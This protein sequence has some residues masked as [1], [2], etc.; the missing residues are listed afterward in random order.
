M[1]IKKI[2]SLSLCLLVGMVLS[3]P[4]QGAQSEKLSK[5]NILK[6]VEEGF[7]EAVLKDP[8]D[9][10]QMDFSVLPG[11]GNFS[12]VENNV[13]NFL[14]RGEFPEV[15]SG[16]LTAKNIKQ[17][18]KELFQLG[19]IAK[20]PEMPT[21]TFPDV[22]LQSP[23][24]PEFLTLYMKYMIERSLA[25]EAILPDKEQV[26]E[27]RKQIKDLKD[28]LFNLAKEEFHEFSPEIIKEQLDIL[29]EPID[30]GPT[31][32]QNTTAKRP[33]TSAQIQNIMYEWG[34]LAEKQTGFYQN[35]IDREKQIR[36]RAGRNIS[37]DEI[38][39]RKYFKKSSLMKYF[40]PFN[41]VL[42]KEYQNVLLKE[43]V[44]PQ[45]PER[46]VEMEKEFDIARG[47]N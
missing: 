12:R 33:L 16:S 47:V 22:V 35:L 34:E 26:N 36:G 45:K 5:Q 10:F 8:S 39:S 15:E 7:Q 21:P 9:A 25:I 37:K 46:L 43:Y 6:Y 38:L 23:D 18:C 30:D 28:T 44:P 42:R 31:S 4:L 3:L 2:S 13:E 40:F 27:I 1:K 29:F 11:Y 19:G 17:I 41:R 32:V 24:L 14:D 20:N